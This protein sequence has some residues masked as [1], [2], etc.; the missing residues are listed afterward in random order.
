MAACLCRLPTR[1]LHFPCFLPHKD[2]STTDYSTKQYFTERRF[3]YVHCCSQKKSRKEK[4]DNLTQNAESKQVMQQTH[5]VEQ[6][7]KKENSTSRIRPTLPTPSTPSRRR[8]DT[9]Q[10]LG[11]SQFSYPLRPPQWPSIR[12]LHHSWTAITN[13][14]G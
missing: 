9:L 5:Y 2:Y 8:L 6:N 14:T 1:W 10:R 7:S 12:L 4:K 13:H 3:K 11:S